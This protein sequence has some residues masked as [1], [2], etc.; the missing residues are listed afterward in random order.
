MPIV[1]L[2]YLLGILVAR[3]ASADLASLTNV[4]CPPLQCD[5]TQKGVL[6][7][8]PNRGNLND[9]ELSGGSR[10]SAACSEIC[11]STPDCDVWMFRLISIGAFCKMWTAEQSPCRP[12]AS[13]KVMYDPIPR[14]EGFFGFGGNCISGDTATIAVADDSATVSATLGHA[15][16]SPTQDGAVGDSDGGDEPCDDDLADDSAT[17]AAEESASAVGSGEKGESLDVTVAVGVTVVAPGNV[18]DPKSLE[19]TPAMAG[20]SAQ[21]GESVGTFRVAAAVGARLRGQKQ[22]ELAVPGFGA[23]EEGKD[24]GGD[25]SG[26]AENSSPLPPVS[27]PLSPARQGNGS[28]AVTAQA[29]PDRTVGGAEGEGALTA[30]AAEGEAGV[31]EGGDA[32]KWHE[33]PTA[34]CPEFRCNWP[35]T[36]FFFDHSGKGHQA[37]IVTPYTNRPF[38][39]WRIC[40]RTEHCAFWM[41]EMK[42]IQ[43]RCKLWRAEQSP[44]EPA[45]P[46][47]VTSTTYQQRA[48]GLFVV[49]GNCKG[50]VETI[51]T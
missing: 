20:P 5:V 37:V 32:L 2:L 15:T 12:D 11:A 35:R 47:D 10:T 34:Q 40:R 26:E 31:A 23:G 18:S 30:S 42:K 49:G 1:A 24:A 51:A 50:G 17:A 13:G 36:G 28:L 6:R 27:A 44:C 43:G 25:D 7:N 22:S 33:G 14:I 45:N 48:D 4:A 41:F 19:I 8:H 3:T 21:E 29:E 46:A 39:C 16:A 38:E 9:V